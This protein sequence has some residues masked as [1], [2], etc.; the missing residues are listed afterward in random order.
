MATERFERIS[1]NL[2]VIQPSDD[3]LEFTAVIYSREMKRGGMIV[4]D[5]LNTLQSLLTAQSSNSDSKVANQKSALV[6]T[7]LQ[8]ISRF[9]SRSLLITNI[10]KARPNDAKESS[11][12]F[13]EKVL[14]GGRMIKFKSDRIL[15]AKKI[16]KVGSPIVEITSQSSDSTESDSFERYQFPVQ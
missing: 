3:V 14:V 13:W 8:Q 5:S 12:S 4:L 1:K 16:V 10:T 6:V 7:L 9:Y 11:S 2:S 15:S